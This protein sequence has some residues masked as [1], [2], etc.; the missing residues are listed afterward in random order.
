[1]NDELNNQNEQNN[2]SQPVVEQSPVVEPTPAVVS[3]M[4]QTPV[5]QPVVDTTPV[6]EPKKKGKGGLIA[7]ILIVVLLLVGGGVFAYFKFFSVTPYSYYQKL[8]TDGITDIFS[9]VH[10]DKIY[11]TETTMDFDTKLDEEL[12][13]KEVAD[14][15]NKLFIK[16]SVQVDKD[17]GKL[18][19]KLDT[20]YENENFL[21]GDLYFDLKGNKAYLYSTDFINK[22]LELEDVSFMGMEDVLNAT[23]DYDFKALEKVLKRELPKLIK[24]EDCSK[25]DD[26]YVLKISNKELLVRVSNMFESLK[27]DN[28]FLKAIGKELADEFVK[29]EAITTDVAEEKTIII[30]SNEKGFNIVSDDTTINGDI[31]GDTVTFK[32][33]MD[34]K[35][36]LN[37]SITIKGGSNDQSMSLTL[38]IPEMGQIKIDLTSKYQKISKVDEVDMNNVKKIEELTQ[39]EQYELQQNL[40]KSKFYS[41]IENYMMMTQGALMENTKCATATC[42]SECEDGYCKCS[43]INE[44]NVTE[45]VYCSIY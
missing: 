11:Q 1:M 23:D 2:I 36:Q 35:E 21:K 14:L 33:T 37:G 13:P 25:E 30:K 20:T 39:E 27:K 44:Y 24:E 26:Y 28:E 7:I 10:D 18:V 17:N 4:Q 31:N 38:N 15:I 42:S 41:I 32:I 22:Y 45:E 34:S 9:N 12:F 29:S 8:I 40:S 5:Q 16:A 43:Y 6:M 3:E 19:T